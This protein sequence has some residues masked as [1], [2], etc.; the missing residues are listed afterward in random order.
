MSSIAWSAKSI[1][2][3]PVDDDE[4]LIIDSAAPTTN[5]RITVGS[6]SSAIFPVSD[7]TAIVKGD[8]DPTQLLR[9]EIS[10]FTSGATRVLTP[11]DAN[12]TIVLQDFA[13][14][15]TNKTMSAAANSF[16][17]FVIGTEVTGASTNLTDTGDIA[18]LNT[19]NT[20]STGLQSFSAATLRIPVSAAPSV[21]VDGDIAY[22]TTVAD[23]S[24]GLVTFFGTEEQGIVSMP[25]AQFTTPS[26]GFVV[27]YNATNDE[28]ELVAQSG[29]GDMILADVQTVT[30]AKTFGTIG[31]DVGK[32]ILAG[33]TSGSTILNAAAVAGST[34]ITLPGTTGTVALTANNLSVFASTTSSQLAGV[35]SD[36]T[37]SGSL[38]FGTSPTLVTPALGTPSALVLTNA[39]GLP[40]SGLADGTDGELI[41][42]DAGGVADTVA[43][44][45]MGQVLTS[46]GVGAPPTFQSAG[47][48]TPWVSDIDADGFDLTSLSNLE[49]QTTTGAPDITAQA[50]YADADGIIINVPTS[51]SILLTINGTD[52]YAFDANDLDMQRNGLFDVENIV[53]GETLGVPGGS[54]HAIYVDTGGMIFNTPST[55]DFD[56]QINADSEYV[57]TTLQAEWNGNDLIEMGILS[58]DDT[59]TSI[60]QATLDLQL[61]V[62]TGGTITLRVNDAT[63]YAFSATQVDFND[64]EIINATIDAADQTLV[65]NIDETMQVVETGAVDTVL[66]SNGATFAPSYKSIPGTGDVVGPGSATDEAIVRFDTATGKLIQNGVITIDDVANMAEIRSLEFTTHTSGPGTSTTHIALVNND[67]HINTVTGNNVQMLIEGNTEY[68]FDANSADFNGNHLIMGIGYIQLTSD[69]S[70]GVTGSVNVGKIFMDSGNSHH[71]SII[72]NGSV[73]DLEEGSQTPWIS[74]IVADGFDLTDLSNI[75]FRETTGVPTSSTPAMYHEATGITINVPTDDSV[76]LD[77]E[78]TTEYTFNLTQADFNDNEIIN[79]TINGEDQTLVSNIDEDMLTVLAGGAGS[80]LTSNGVSLAPSYES[81]YPLNFPEFAGGD[82]TNPQNISFASEERHSQQFTLIQ[83]TTLS[84]SGEVSDTTEYIDL[85]IIQDGTGGWTLTLPSGTVNKTEVEAGIN[86]GAGEETYILLKYAFGTFYAFLQGSQ[87]A[88][89][90]FTWTADHSMATFKLTATA[91]NDVILNAPTGQGVSIEVA[92]TEEY[93]FNATLADFNGNNLQNAPQILDSNGA[94]LLIFTTTASAVNE[95]TLVNAAT[96][97]PVEIQASGETNVDVQFTPKGTGTFYGNRETWA[98]PLTDE[99]TA[100]T[101]GVKYTTEPAPYDMSIEDAIAGLTTAGTGAALFTIDVLKENS[102]NAD[103]FTTIFSTLVTIDASE[104]TSTTAATAPVISVST[105]EKGRRLQL[106]IDTLDTDTLGRGAKISLVTHATAK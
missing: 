51:D 28:F 37:G 102:V 4:L 14:T 55:D 39:T 62:A 101:T 84:F 31:G 47:S 87:P 81:L 40:V 66:T 72:R 88:D 80:V 98:W 46:N 60:Q 89:E 13:Q 63:E 22:D 54:S 35:I 11:P 69:T 94:E 10:G 15:L 16:S 57:L 79:A 20:W 76:S 68:Q 77:V 9:F 23:F 29:G 36:E 41:T 26:N 43:V 78:G 12:G 53:F 25:I 70:P 24:T 83:N 91:A 48:Q 90:V 45:T 2:A 50:I 1:K 86:T 96:G 64:N 3:T 95:L 71:L 8:S 19:A 99:T 18:Y 42:W 93:L 97:T 6:L 5:K 52:E 73:I 100:P 33:S 85:F 27:S 7:A 106:S 103:A 65:S 56:F 67:F 58:F 59:D 38:V 92:A 49:F 104:F 82:A 21:T 34:T 105:W 74:N 75:E 30:G 32:F 44:G 17:G 61:D